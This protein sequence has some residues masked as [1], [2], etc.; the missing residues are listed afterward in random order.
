MPRTCNLCGVLDFRGIAIPGICR[1]FRH[2]GAPEWLN[3]DSNRYHGHATSVEYLPSVVLQYQRLNGKILTSGR[4]PRS[5][6]NAIDRDRTRSIAIDRDRKIAIPGLRFFPEKFLLGKG[7]FAKMNVGSHRSRHGPEWLNGD[8]N[9]YHGHATSL[10][11]QKWLN[12]DRNRYH[13]LATS[14][15]YS[16]PGYRLFGGI[17]IP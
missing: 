10:G 15:E 16:N 1:K 17:A 12:G 9:Q 4:V 7:D 2:L 6:S 3:G 13:G 14:V 11:Y 5:R 8:R